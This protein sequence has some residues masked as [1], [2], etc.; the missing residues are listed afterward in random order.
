MKNKIIFIISLI[1]IAGGLGYYVKSDLAKKSR[2]LPQITDQGK[3]VEVGEKTAPREELPLE[4]VGVE[5]NAKPSI[6][7]PNLNRPINITGNLSEAE[8]KAV[9]AK[10]AEISSALKESPD[11]F[12]SWLV[13]GIYRKMIGDYEGAREIWE[14]AAALRPGD[15]I[16][17]NNLG[18]L[19]AYYLKDTKKAEEYFSKAVELSPNRVHL[20]Q[21]FYDFYRYVMKDDAKAKAILEKGI[22][23][24][25]G[26][27]SQGLQTLLQDY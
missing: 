24:N 13:L 17:F 4:T 8:K 21:S 1:L 10:I 14:Y 9:T 23:A 16:P 25:P 19:Y 26:S 11:L 20:Y 22:A 3:S 12:E 7:I 6:P 15:F 27:A 18:D 2:Q 5:Q